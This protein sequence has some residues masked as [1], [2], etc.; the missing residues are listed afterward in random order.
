MLQDRHILWNDDWKFKDVVERCQETIAAFKANREFWTD[1]A[2]DWPERH[3]RERRWVSVPMALRLVRSP[4]LRRLIADFCAH[5]PTRRARLLTLL[6]R[7][8]SR[9]RAPKPRP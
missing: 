5:Q 7:M 8:A 1:E 6:V 4:E 9:R 3:E 2:E